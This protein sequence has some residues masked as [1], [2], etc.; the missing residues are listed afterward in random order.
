MP[1][2][3]SRLHPLHSGAL[4]RE[5]AARLGSARL[6]SAG[7]G[8]ARLGSARLGSARLG[9]ALLGSAPLRSARAGGRGPLNVA[10][11]LGFP[12]PRSPPCPLADARARVTKLK[13]PPSLTSHTAPD[14]RSA[15]GPVGARGVVACEQPRGASRSAVAAALAFL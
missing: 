2:A 12:K 7:F 13:T 11:G 10:P 4:A 1:V 9:S 3:P 14:C 15:R 8:S 5:R 6:S